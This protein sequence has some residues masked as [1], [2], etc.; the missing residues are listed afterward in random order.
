[1]SLQFQSIKQEIDQVE[2]VSFDVFDTLIKRMTNSPESIFEIVGYQFDILNFSDLRQRDQALA[3]EKAEREQHFPHADIHQIYDYIYKHEN[4]SVDWDLVKEKEV[5]AEQDFLYCNQEMYMVYQYA[6]QS[7]KRVIITSDM[8]L[9]REQ[10]EKILN[11]CGYTQYDEIYLSSEVHTTKYI[12]DIFSYICSKEHVSPDKILHIGDNEKSD[13]EN[14]KKYGFRAYLYAASSVND[15]QKGLYPSPVDYGVAESLIGENK[16][17]WYQLG[18]IVGGPLYTGIYQW[19]REQLEQI[20]FEKIYF[21]SR[22]GYN[23]YHIFKK[24]QQYGCEYLYVSRRSMLL[25]GIQELDNTTLDLL[26]PYT[27]GQTVGEIL[28]YLGLNIE[29]IHYLKD[30]GLS[31]MDSIIRNKEDIQKMRQLYVLNQDVFLKKCEEERKNAINYFLKS[32]FFDQNNVVFDCGWNGSSQYLMDRFLACTDFKHENYFL[33]V[34]ILDS[35]KSRRQLK[36]K[37]YSTYL[38]D[39]SSDRGM[40]EKVRESI[41]IFELFF[42]APHQSVLCYGKDGI[43]YEKL[44]VDE[45]YKEK[46][47]QGICDYVSRAIPLVQKYQIRISKENAISDVVRDEFSCYERSKNDWEPEKC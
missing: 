29:S 34:G 42:G 41:V 3:S 33:Y 37:K 15:E 24:C 26:P 16:D 12:G 27:F 6:L 4:D 40:Q 21:L 13:F 36:N 39:Y 47:S 9:T 17:F 18:V 11:K 22:D 14:A 32:G 45:I 8:Y 5:E 35:E 23:L 43:V 38:F 28:E 25:A 10:I 20:G 46:I 7:G 19:F 1:M 44:N 30:A 31:G 2:V